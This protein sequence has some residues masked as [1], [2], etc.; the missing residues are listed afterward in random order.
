MLIALFVPALQVIPV[1][2]SPAL[3]P[4]RESTYPDGIEN[5]THSPWE[6]NRGQ[7]VQVTVTLSEDATEPDRMSLLWCRVEPDYV[8]AIPSLMVRNDDGTWS[9]TIDGSAGGDRDVIRDN[10]RHIGYNVTQIYDHEDQASERV[11]APLGNFWAPETFPL[12][13]GGNYY[14]LDLGDT[15]ESPVIAIFPL[16]FALVALTALTRNSHRG[17]TGSG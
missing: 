15:N 3:L 2:A 8:C 13:T 1:A 4:D 5:I 7:D 6:V 17:G 9:G 16:L 11:Y 12:D 14:F 10:T